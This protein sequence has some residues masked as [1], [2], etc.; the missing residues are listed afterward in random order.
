VYKSYPA[1]AANNSNYD[2]IQQINI[3]KDYLAMPAKM[4]V[5]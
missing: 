5:D 2:Y 4:S 1:I 3:E